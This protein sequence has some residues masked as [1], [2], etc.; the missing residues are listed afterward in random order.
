MDK[1]LQGSIFNDC[2]KYIMGLTINNLII[3]NAIRFVE[4]QSKDKLKKSS[5]QEDKE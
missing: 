2:D 4:K 1:Q 3:T 5:D